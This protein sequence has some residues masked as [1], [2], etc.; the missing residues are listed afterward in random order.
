LTWLEE[1]RVVGPACPPACENAYHWSLTD[2]TGRSVVVQYLK[3]QRKVYENTPRVLTNDPALEWHWQN[4]NTYVNVSPEYP[5]DNDFL[6]VET[7]IGSVPQTVG[8][9]WNLGGL[10]GDGSPSSRFVNLF[11]LRGYAMHQAPPQTVNDAI[12]LASGL[13]NRVF[14]PV[15]IFASDKRNP[16]D[17]PEATPYAVVKIPAEK[18]ILIRSYKNLQWHQV[19]LNRIDFTQAKRRPVEDGTLG[20][21]DIT[22]QFEEDPGASVM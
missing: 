21:K 5:H 18:R 1:H 9:G 8:H 3:G 16:D 4:L 15:G 20:I 14:I 11:Y 22:M 12:V 2:M 6:S 7:S 10:P 17:K 19:D 13:L